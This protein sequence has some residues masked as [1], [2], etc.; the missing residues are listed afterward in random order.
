MSAKE[1]TRRCITRTI[2]RVIQP[3]RIA[4]RVLLLALTRVDR[5]RDRIRLRARSLCLVQ[6]PLGLHAIRS[7]EDAWVRSRIHRPRGR[8]GARRGAVRRGPIQ[9]EGHQLERAAE[10]ES[11]AVLRGRLCPRRGRRRASWE[12]GSGLHERGEQPSKQRR[13]HVNAGVEP[14][15]WPSRRGSV[16]PFLF[17]LARTRSH[18]W[19]SVCGPSGL[20]QALEYAAP[21]RAAGMTATAVVALV[22][23]R[24]VSSRAYRPVQRPPFAGRPLAL[25][26]CT[27]ALSRASARVSADARPA[28]ATGATTERL[29]G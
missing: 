6:P 29:P 26:A 4:K 13:A 2:F 16:L 7:Q 12:R 10:L 15:A 21:R 8:L 14:W 23:R 11:D 25:L 22:V 18:A 27:R 20:I 24:R 5:T 3:E 17:V 28:G 1:E 9:V 19:S